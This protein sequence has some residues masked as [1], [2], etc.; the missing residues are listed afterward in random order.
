MEIN[1]F[2]PK[3]PNNFACEFCS[4]ITCNKK[5]YSRHLLTKKHII[6]NYQC[7]SIEKSQ[8]NPYECICGK[9]YKENSGLWRHKKVCKFDHKFNESISNDKND[10]LIEYLMK[11]NKE[12]KEMILEIVKNGT[13][14]NDKNEKII[15][16]ISKVTTIK[17]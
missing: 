17:Q 12:I 15:T 11:E 8:K 13:M 1:D 7:V 10:K 9:I 14:N 2:Y 6:N 3:K 5:D 4:F 16:N